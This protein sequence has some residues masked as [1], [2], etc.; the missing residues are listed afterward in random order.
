META[1]TNQDLARLPESRVLFMYL[2]AIRVIG[3][4]P[5]NMQANQPMQTTENPKTPPMPLPRRE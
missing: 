5:A 2:R 4:I 3:F 1:A